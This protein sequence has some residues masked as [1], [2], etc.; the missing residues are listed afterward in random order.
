MSTSKDLQ[1]KGLSQSS[2]TVFEDGINY[3][4]DIFEKTG[5]D[6]QALFK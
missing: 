3:C 4:R 2:S 1:V 6:K 5:E